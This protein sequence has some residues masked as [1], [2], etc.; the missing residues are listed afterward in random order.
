MGRIYSKNT[1]LTCGT[2]VSMP[3]TRQKYHCP[4]YKEIMDG[5]NTFITYF[6]VGYLRATT[7]AVYLDVRNCMT[8]E[9]S[10]VLIRISQNNKNTTLL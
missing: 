2:R 1:D 8:T 4:R 3:V 7:N 9:A 5:Y 6:I 10:K